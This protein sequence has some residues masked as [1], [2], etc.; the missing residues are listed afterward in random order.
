MCFLFLLVCLCGIIALWFLVFKWLMPTFETIE[1]QMWN[2]F[3]CYN[4][5]KIV[6]K[7][8][9]ETFC[10]SRWLHQPFFFQL[11]DMLKA[12]RGRCFHAR[13]FTVWRLSD[14]EAQLI[15]NVVRS[16]W[17]YQSETDVSRK[18]PSE[19]FHFFFLWK[20]LE[21]FLNHTT[22]KNYFLPTCFFVHLDWIS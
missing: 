3:Y 13:Y 7:K 2:F 6:Y 8:A 17:I 16:S 18:H 11:T 4:F 1:W 9:P 21:V 14:S 19:V 12:C 5:L 20:P 22:D 10:G 15:M